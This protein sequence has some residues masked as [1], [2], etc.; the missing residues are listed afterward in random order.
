M[1]R[2]A[3]VELD[4]ETVAYP[5][6]ELEMLRA[7]NDR[8]GG[9]EIVALWEPGTASALDAGSVS[10]GRDVGAVAT[11]D[12]Q[13]D[14]RTLTFVHNGETFVDKETGSEW[15]FLGQAVSGPLAGQSL[16]PVVNV[17]HF[18]FSWAAFRP[19][20]RIHRAQEATVAPQ[21]PET[22]PG[23]PIANEPVATNV[24]VPFDF[25]IKLYQGQETLGGTRVNFSDA[26]DGKPVVA[27]L[28]A[29]LCPT[30]RRELPEMQ[31]AYKE[32]GDRITFVGI[33]IG[34]FTGLGFEPEGR[35]LLQQLEITFPAGG[36]PD[37]EFMRQYRI[38]GTPA[39]IFFSAEG[40]VVNQWSGLIPAKQLRSNLE[41]LLDS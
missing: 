41:E 13:L 33:D 15:T 17:N 29:G 20:T 19:E 24:Q 6:T 37:G 10:G 11:F 21:E 22:K 36:P 18:W 28:W 34:P 32:Y 3:T 25:E 5:Y 35:A 2:V 26:F 39:S 7:I 9:R 8:V 31:E 40:E 12:R 30:C 1:A 23:A 4:G 38:L 16:A 14:G 27:V